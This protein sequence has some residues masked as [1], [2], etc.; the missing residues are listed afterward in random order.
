SDARWGPDY[1]FVALDFGQAA[2]LRGAGN[3]DAFLPLKSEPLDRASGDSV[4][5]INVGTVVINRLIVIG[6][7]RDVNG[8]L[9]VSDVLSHRHD[10]LA[11]NGLAN[12]ANVHKVVVGGTNVELHVD[13]AAN[14]TAVSDTKGFWRQWRPTDVVASG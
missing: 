3:I 13:G 9:N 5:D 7:V 12:I 14:R 6:N 10:A 11:K 4:N 1:K 8:L 2:G